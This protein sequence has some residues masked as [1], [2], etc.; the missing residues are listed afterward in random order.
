[1]AQ[2][3]ATAPPNRRHMT[4]SGL[5]RPYKVKAPGEKRFQRSDAPPPSTNL[6]APATTKSGAAQGAGAGGGGNDGGGVT[7]TT[8]TGTKKRTSGRAQTLYSRFFGQT[9]SASTI[10]RAKKASER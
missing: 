6:G 3:R 10:R 7:G 1:M 5:Q 8:K 4:K 2:R 9:P